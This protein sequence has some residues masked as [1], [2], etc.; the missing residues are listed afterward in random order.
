MADD[1]PPGCVWLVGA[2][3]GDPELLTR[4]AER[5]IAAADVLFH[6]ALVGPDVLALARPDAEL[7][8]VGKRSG[9]H[10]RDQGTI[11]DLLLAAA[12][13]GR[14]VV[15]LKGGD[16]FVLGRGGEEL[17][18]CLAAGVEVEVVPGV[19]SAF[20][21]PAAAG[22]PVTHRKVSRQVTVV[23]AHDAAPD[24]PAL[25]R[26]D[27]TLVL[28]MGVTRLKEHAARLVE[29]GRA[30]TTP[31]AVIE[32]GTTAD[33]R[34]TVGTLADIA[35]LAA[36]RAVRSPAVVVVGPVVE[37]AASLAGTYRTSS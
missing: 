19:T 25:A 37:L 14:R 4:K 22:I 27:G 2:G 15:R 8:S 11:N 24:W 31:V 33:Q 23:S 5:L 36:A 26:L 6:D 1:F 28:L 35:E 18:A 13:A 32:R 30:A 12:R 17:L 7:V 21:V 29:L 16:P 20:A 10:S 3:P 9:R 34:T